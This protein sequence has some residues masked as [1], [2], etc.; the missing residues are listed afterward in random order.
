M[1]AALITMTTFQIFHGL[2]EMIRSD[3]ATLP[4]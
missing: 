4:R 3:T 1:N 2:C